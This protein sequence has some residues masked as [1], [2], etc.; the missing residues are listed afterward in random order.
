MG[1]MTNTTHVEIKINQTHFVLCNRRLQ[2]QEGKVHDA[3]AWQRAYKQN[4][5]QLYPFK[6]VI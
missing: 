1:G 4:A 3:V 2:R 6:D 5:Y